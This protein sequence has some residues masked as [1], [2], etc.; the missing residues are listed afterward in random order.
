MY[1]FCRTGFITEQSLRGVCR[2]L[3]VPISELE[4]SQLMA[5]SVNDHASY[6]LHRFFSTSQRYRCDQDRDGKISYVEFTKY[7]TGIHTVMCIVS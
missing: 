6:C 7:L 4:I 5:E 1:Y 3:G 2:D